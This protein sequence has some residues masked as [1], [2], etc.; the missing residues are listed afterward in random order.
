[1]DTAQASREA[2]G[3]RMED[4]ERL[5]IERFRLRTITEDK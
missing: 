2:E 4:E 3:E 1:M 5:E